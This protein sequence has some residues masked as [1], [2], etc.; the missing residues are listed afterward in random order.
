MILKYR[1]EDCQ[2]WHEASLGEHALLTIYTYQVWNLIKL[3]PI[4]LVLVSAHIRYKLQLKF[5]NNY[6]KQT[7]RI[8]FSL[9]NFEKLI[10]NWILEK[11]WKFPNLIKS[12]TSWLNIIILKILSFLHKFPTQL[13]NIFYLAL[14]RTPFRL[15][16]AWIILAFHV[17]LVSVKCFI[18][19]CPQT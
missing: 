1:Q 5:V 9:E 17:V 16:F 4:K 11:G 18:I 6:W 7:F 12:I 14:P 19:P 2:E 10:L 8:L 15:T 3:L 13:C